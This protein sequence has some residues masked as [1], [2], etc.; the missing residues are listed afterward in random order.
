MMDVKPY[1]NPYEEG[2]GDKVS[3]AVAVYP[4][5]I[6]QLDALRHQ[7]MDAVASSDD[8]TTLVICLNMLTKQKKHNRKNHQGLTD[9]EL[10]AKLAASVETDWDDE[11]HADLSHID[12]SK[13]K[14]YRSAKVQ[15]SLEKWL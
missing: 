14:P 10:E 3:E 6:H 9:E 1:R 15:K 8:K 4:S 7:V 2:M 11:K 12:Y 13:Y 5:Q